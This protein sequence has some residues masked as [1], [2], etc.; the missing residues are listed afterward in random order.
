MHYLKFPDGPVVRTW[1]FHCQGLGS[2][3]S[4]GTKILQAIIWGLKKK[5]LSLNPTTLLIEI[6]S[7]DTMAYMQEDVCVCMYIWMF[8]TV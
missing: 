7:V 2:I 8:I 3:P 5:E 1:H 4:G 6:Y